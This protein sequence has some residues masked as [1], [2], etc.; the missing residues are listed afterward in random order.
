MSPHF[1]IKHK[2][3]KRIK[4]LDTAHPVF[5]AADLFAGIEQSSSVKSEHGLEKEQRR[6]ATTSH[7]H[8]RMMGLGSLVPAGTAKPAAAAATA[9]SSNVRNSD[10]TEVGKGMKRK[11]KHAGEVRV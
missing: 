10:L 4:Q 6:P 3:S 2:H 1:P 5:H 9:Y 11:S 7:I 8:W